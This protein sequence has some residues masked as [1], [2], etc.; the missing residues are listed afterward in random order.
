MIIRLKPNDAPLR[1]VE[2][3]PRLRLHTLPRR[4]GN[5][6]TTLDNNLHLVIVI[7]VFELLALFEAVETAAD[8]LFGVVF[9]AAPD[10]AEEVVVVGDEGW[11]VLCGG[12]GVMGHGDCVVGAHGCEFDVGFIQG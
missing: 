8:R 12:G 11:G 5:R 7:R 9:V 2:H 6:P 1:K 3:I 10:V 4:I